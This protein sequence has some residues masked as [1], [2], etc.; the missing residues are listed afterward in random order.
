MWRFV[1][2]ISAL[3]ALTSG[4]AIAD[5]TEQG[6]D[7]IVSPEILHRLDTLW[8]QIEVSG[9]FEKKCTYK[10]PAAHAKRYAEDNDLNSAWQDRQV[11]FRTKVGSTL[12][13]LEK[14]TSIQYLVSNSITHQSDTTRVRGGCSFSS[15][16]DPMSRAQI[17]GDTLYDVEQPR[18]W[19][20][21]AARYQGQIVTASVQLTE[22]F[23]W[24]TSG[25]KL[26]VI[27]FENPLNRSKGLTQYSALR[28]S[29]T[30]HVLN[31]NVPA[32]RYQ[33]KYERYSANVQCELYYRKHGERKAI[34]VPRET[35]SAYVHLLGEHT[36]EKRLLHPCN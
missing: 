33:Q 20:A 6:A 30:E 28:L 7:L 3:S 23:A 22:W 27:F 5:T 9:D 32:P 24:H 1:L 21:E 29:Y 11:L 4:L 36:H 12:P 35:W 16:V 34:T 8:A 19:I 25:A 18:N 13:G 10:K 2:T 14:P 17:V 26:Y 15:G 31:T